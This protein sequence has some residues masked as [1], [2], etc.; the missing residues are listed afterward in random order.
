[1][2]G[3]ELERN[4][5]IALINLLER[6]S[7]SIGYYHTM[8]LALAKNPGSISHRPALSMSEAVA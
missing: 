4:E 8:S 1:M 5:V 3:L 2:E 7:S 6:F